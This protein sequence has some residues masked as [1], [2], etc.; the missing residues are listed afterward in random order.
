MTTKELRMEH[1]KET[2]VYPGNVPGNS[3]FDPFN[4]EKSITHA[5]RMGL[6][7][8]ID[9]LENKILELKNEQ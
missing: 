7:N 2:G 5:N 4:P 3:T 9:W 1:Q 6:L 8:Y